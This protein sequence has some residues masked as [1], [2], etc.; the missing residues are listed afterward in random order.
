M[1]RKVNDVIQAII[2]MEVLTAYKSNPTGEHVEV[3][4]RSNE[5]LLT[6]HPP[7]PRKR[8]ALWHSD[9]VLAGPEALMT[10]AAHFR[11]HWRVWYIG[12]PLQL[13][14]FSCSLGLSERSFDGGL[15]V[16]YWKF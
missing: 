1:V 12:S 2:W 13:T 6:L 4:L 5:E 3:S 16:H 14:H 7:P 9:C 11:Q 8:L 10:S 15:R